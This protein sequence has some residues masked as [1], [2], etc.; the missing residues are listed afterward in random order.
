MNL[1][2]LLLATLTSVA[3]A[4]P[5]LDSLVSQI[6]VIENGVEDPFAVNDSSIQ[7]AIDLSDNGQSSNKQQKKKKTPEQQRQTLLQKLWIDRTPSGILEARLTYN[8]EQKEAAEARNDASAEKKKPDS[9]KEKKELTEKQKDNKKLAQYKKDVKKLTQDVTLGHWDD[10]KT[11][12]ETLPDSAAE[13]AF[14]TIVRVLGQ[15]V[16]V[17]PRRELSTVGAR[18]HKQ[19]QYLRPDEVLA[20][21]DAAKKA[22]SNDLIENLAQLIDRDNRPS[23]DF[24]EQL[25]KGTR[26]FGLKDLE[27]KHRTAQFLIDANYLKEAQPF[28]PSI[29]EAKKDNKFETLNLIARFN[30]EA[31][32]ENLNLDYGKTHLPQAWELSLGLIGEKE[33]P[34]PQRNEALYRALSLVPELQGET[35]REWLKNTFATSD[36]EGFEILAAVGTL[37]AQTREHHS[38]TFRLEQL[39]LQN[40]AVKALLEQ[41]NLDLNPWAEILTLYAVNWNEEAERTRRL[42]PGDSRSMQ[43]EWD[44]Y[45]NIYYVRKRSDYRGDGPRPINAGDLLDVA[46]ITQG[47]WL[48]ALDDSV[49]L[50]S[51][52]RASQLFLKLKEE[53]NAFPF[54]QAYSKT[55]P[56]KA[57]DLVRELIRVWAQNHNPNQADRYRNRYSYFYG[58]N[59]RAESIPLTR[60]KQERNLKELSELIVEIKKLNLNE[61]FQEELADAFVQSHSKAEVWRVETLTSVF[62][63]VEQ[64]DPGTLASLLARMRTNLAGLWPDP[65]LQKQAKTN[66]TDQELQAQIQQG[67][68]S[69]ITLCQQFLEVNNAASS[70]PI[71][72]QLAALQYEESNY[73]STL[74]PQ[75]DHTATKGTAL[76]LLADA[77]ETYSSTL[78][79]EDQSKESLDAFTN[80]FFGALGSPDLAALKGTHQPIPTEY[81]KVKA[82][83]NALP[84]TQNVRQ[85]HIDGFAKIINQRL[86]NVPSDLKHRYLQ[87]ALPIVEDHPETKEARDVFQYYKDL[88]NEIELNTHIDGLDRID[89]S[90]PFGLYVNIRH[91]KE[92]ER[93][94]GGFQRYLVNQNNQRYAYNFGRPLEDYRDKFEKAAR[95]ALSEHFE[96]VSLTFHN[97]KV[98]SRTDPQVGWRYT[99][100]AYFL[101]KPKGPEVD[102]IPPL[103]IDLDFLDTSGHVVLPVSSAAIPIDATVKESPRPYRD[104]KIA[105]TVDS[106]K[107]EEDQKLALEIRTT[108]HGII[109][110]LNQLVDLPPPGFEIVAT[111]DRELQLEELD[112]ATQDGAPLTSHEWKLTLSPKSDQMPKE[113]AFP[114]ILSPPTNGPDNGSEGEETEAK[115]SEEEPPVVYQQYEDVD[116]VEVPA[117]IPLSPE[118]STSIPIFWYLLA[119]AIGLVLIYLIRRL[120]GSSS[121]EKPTLPVPENLTPV[122]VLSFLKSL[123]NHASLPSGKKED[124][125]ED[126]ATLQK[127]SFA[128]GA[129]A[130]PASELEQMAKHWQRQLGF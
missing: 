130:P 102:A 22:P 18:R 129:Q 16:N 67:Y 21:C 108:A 78:P 75:N 57:I 60:S 123:Q 100:Y 2:L 23:T 69:A 52:A 87:A 1:Q 48:D 31:H 114:A 105:L 11:Y 70:W 103:Q 124:L 83:L 64:I 89:A 86:A 62:G 12:L 93:E 96:I 53:E 82:A 107:I 65:R 110:E 126:I 77:A 99:P 26:Y 50:T 116:L 27:T 15:E 28:I 119:A 118:K 38:D 113:F 49:R 4:S 121:E 41:G 39:K 20:L 104:L 63:P 47:K 66:R 59:Q 95:N 115:E 29:E 3:G 19:S 35:G 43:A 24:F 94:S 58:S 25:K 42:D 45:G 73:K 5:I 71:E 109:P 68:Q 91:T 120:S 8:R 88:V 34:L 90:R 101:L 127:Q 112:A 6:T 106:R 61:T 84:T 10:V 80:W 128:P 36:G 111:E 32:Q 85:R 7:E 79:L 125:S 98:E 37:T 97:D 46:P 55:E 76:L 33:A 51:L 56:D 40:A 92:I 30:A 72:T 74:K 117:V 122:T 13:T 17:S 9:E 44:D 81:A 14:S 54:L